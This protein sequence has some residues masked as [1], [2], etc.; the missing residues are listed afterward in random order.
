MGLALLNN[1]R[2]G[3]AFDHLMTHMQTGEK[4]NYVQKNNLLFFPLEKNKITRPVGLQ[5][6]NDSKFD[7]VYHSAIHFNC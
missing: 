1:G 2:L 4:D 7:D 6:G 3:G 5:L